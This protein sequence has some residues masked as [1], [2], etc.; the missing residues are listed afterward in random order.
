M[1]ELQSQDE[2]FEE[3]ESEEVEQADV[4]EQDNDADLATDSEPEHEEN[5]EDD[6]EKSNKVNQEA[7]NKV[8]NRK[9]YEAQE[10]K[11]QAEEY[12]RQLEQYQQQQT[13]QAPQVPPRPDPFDDDYDTK[14]A[15][16][17]QAVAAKGRYE[18][19][20]QLRQQQQWEQTQ[21]QQQE[22]QA[23]MQE[24]LTKYVEVGKKAGMS[25]EEMTQAGQ[26]VESYG[27]T[28]DLQNY[29]LTDDDG[30]LIVKHLA[31]NPVLTAELSNMTPYQAAIYLERSVRPQALKLKPKTTAAPNPAKRVQSGN[32]DPDL[33]RFKHIGGAKFE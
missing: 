14:M 21:R 32:V 15:N 22:Q 12:K 6:V 9:H 10:A 1:S 29:L 30:P 24:G 7:I 31:A 2:H 26:M 20:Q 23:K 27:L 8:I 25:V 33:G 5:T 3:V 11:R 16:Y 18:Y 4:E 19:E 28:V 17:E 13:S